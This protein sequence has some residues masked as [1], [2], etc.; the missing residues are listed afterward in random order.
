MLQKD[1]G[2]DKKEGIKTEIGGRNIAEQ[3]AEMVW[4]CVKN[5]REKKTQTNN[6]GKNGRKK[7]EK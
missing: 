5:G 4:T 2:E 3:A 7:R 1:N 6:R